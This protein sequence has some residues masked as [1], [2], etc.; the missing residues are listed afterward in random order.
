MIR[1]SNLPVLLVIALYERQKYR[2]TSLLEQLGD[3]AERYV[4]SLPRRLRAA[5]TLSTE[6]AGS[7]LIWL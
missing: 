4:G 3:F 1:L 7:A 2:E 6:I 5:G